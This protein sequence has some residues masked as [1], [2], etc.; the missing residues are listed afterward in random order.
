MDIQR[1]HE[2][3][4]TRRFGRMFIGLGKNMLWLNG[5]LTRGYVSQSF[6]LHKGERALNCYPLLLYKDQRELSESLPSSFSDTKTTTT[7]TSDFA[8]SSF[9]PRESLDQAA[10]HHHD[11]KHEPP[12]PAPDMDGFRHIPEGELHESSERSEHTALRPNDLRDPKVSRIFEFSIEWMS[13]LLGIRS[14]FWPFI[15]GVRAEYGWSWR[16]DYC[17]RRFGN[18]GRI[19]VASLIWRRAKRSGV[20]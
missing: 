6:L 4:P 18:I 10:H 19:E 14:E 17:R 11:E 3:S 20:I 16:P 7:T 1:M 5:K 13:S 12:A 2:V 8:L 9:S 15:L